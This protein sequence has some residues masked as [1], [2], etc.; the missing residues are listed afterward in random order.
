MNT[1]T[2]QIEL[3]PNPISNY[4]F[5]LKSFAAGIF[6][7]LKL[8]TTTA[9]VQYTALPDNKRSNGY[10]PNVSGLHGISYGENERDQLFYG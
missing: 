5:S 4:F 3:N 9:S 1:M 7:A 10:F 2:V 8:K 6:S